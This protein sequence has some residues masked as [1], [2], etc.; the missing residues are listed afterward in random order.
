MYLNTFGIALQ[1]RFGRTESTEDID[2]AIATIEEAVSST[3]N[4]N[5]KDAIYLNNLGNALQRRFAKSGSMED[6]NHSIAV[7]EEAVKL[8]AD[9]HPRFALFVNNLGN[10]LQSQFEQTGSI[11]VIN[12]AI[13][14]HEQAVASTPDLHPDRAGRLIN[15]GLAFQSRF[16]QTKSTEDLE[17]S[18]AQY[19]QALALVTAPSSIRIQ[20]AIYAFR[21]F[22]DHDPHRARPFLRSAV[23]LLPTISPRVLKQSDQQ[24]NISEYGGITSRAVSVSLD[25]GE[26][27]YDVL[28]LL[29]LGRGI[30]ASL[31]LEV[32]SDISVLRQSFPHLGQR[33]D[34]LR[35]KL[36]QPWRDDPVK[37]EQTNPDW[38]YRR[39]LSKQFE[40]LLTDIR[41]ING[42]KNFLLGPSNTELKKMAA[43]GPIVVFNVS[44]IRSHAFLLGDNNIRAIQLAKLKFSDLEAH[45]KSFLAV[46]ADVKAYENS[47]HEINR[48]LQWLWDVAVGPILDELGFTETPAREDGWPRIW[49][50]C[51]G[52][53]SIL[54]L[55]AA[56]YHDSGSTK[57]A[58]DRVI[59]SYTPTVKSLAYARE[60]AVRAE[61][62]E[63]QRAM[64][65]GMP[66]TPGVKTLAW[67]T[68]E[69][70]MLQKL[71]SSHIQTTVVE[72]PTKV[73]V[74][75]MLQDYQIVHLAC[76][77]YSSA[78]D[79][80]QSKLLLHDWQTSPL[81]V[82]DLTSM[83]I[84]LP[85]F[86]YLSACDAAS[87]RDFSLLDESIHLSSAILLAGYP[88]VVG[89][90]WNVWDDHSAEIAKDVYFWMLEGGKLDPLR[91]AEGL[92]RAVRALRDRTRIVPGFSRKVS[93][94]PLVWAPYIHLGV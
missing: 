31:Q 93:N 5:T 48:V 45:V 41:G 94:D 51:S 65:V 57:N 54:P 58:I 14:K 72:H 1:S 70:E 88:S 18:V 60:R 24:Y 46:P 22:I 66:E 35:A 42:F 6:L 86:A 3:V 89:T 21:L 92:H 83:N 37:L 29:E 74:L 78:V 81:T 50:V 90:L 7:T 76:H 16:Q 71:L 23:E 28:R 20:A 85:Q 69:V 56:G 47:K 27:A 82:S 25:C 11:E 53:L 63:E 61:S 36:D 30:L 73:G 44:Q 15:L 75:S 12:D 10:A 68:K 19:E 87:I 77:G 2:R 13:T 62:L 9:D 91:S 52:L 17:H 84:K 8:T 64:L 26:D 43:W 79:P 59:S 55:H 33:F 80:S 67:V 49:W 4:R 34:D 40:S 32:R 38:N 39:D